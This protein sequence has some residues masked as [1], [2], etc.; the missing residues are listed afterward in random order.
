MTDSTDQSGSTA[1]EPGSQ[2]HFHKTLGMALRLSEAID[3]ALEGMS[4]WVARA[5]KPE[6]IARIS[7]VLQMQA[8]LLVCQGKVLAALKV[9]QLLAA[10]DAGADI[11][12][13]IMRRA[14]S[15]MLNVR[16][17][18]EPPRTRPRP[19]HRA[20]DSH[21]TDSPSGARRVNLLQPIFTGASA[22]SRAMAP[23]RSSATTANL[24][25]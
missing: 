10:A 22:R 21:N 14:A 24:Q 7:N 18:A 9:A 23:E 11:G 6:Q 16:S 20:K 25:L 3:L 15:G 19:K 8:E 12:A 1:C 17:A 2:E 13:E 5:Q 4:L